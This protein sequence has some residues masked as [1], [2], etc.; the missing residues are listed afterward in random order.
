MYG[1]IIRRL[2]ATIPVMIILSAL[3]G[4]NYGAN[5]SLFPSV[6]KDFYGINHFG[7]NYGIVFTAW[8]AGGFMLSLLAGSLYDVHQT[9][10]IAYYGAAGL[11]LAAAVVSLF[12]KGPHRMVLR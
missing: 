2:L 3:I 4:A 10:A 9:F 11:L 7:T 8:G 1:Y 12:L 5:L 6:T